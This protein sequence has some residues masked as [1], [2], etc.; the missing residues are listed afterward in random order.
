MHGLPPTRAIPAICKTCASPHRRGSAPVRRGGVEA[1]LVYRTQQN[2]LAHGPEPAG[3]GFFG[4]ERDKRL[5]QALG[6]IIAHQD[7]E[8][9]KALAERDARI[10]K[11][12]TQLET[13]V[14]VIG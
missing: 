5:A 3:A 9:D 6:E 12:E 13:L 7:R 2:A 11:L 4:D 1:T 10:S 8:L 14:A